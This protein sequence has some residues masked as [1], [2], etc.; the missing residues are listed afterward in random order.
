[1]NK[2][3]DLTSDDRFPKN[4]AMK[5][6]E[7]LIPM[8]ETGWAKY[9]TRSP[10]ARSMKFF[11]PF[12]SSVSTTYANFDVRL[13][14]EFLYSSKNLRYLETLLKEKGYRCQRFEVL[15]DVEGTTLITGNV[16]EITFR[17]RP[18]SFKKFWT[19]RR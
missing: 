11:F 14:S 4:V 17:R 8:I 1:M 5:N 9:L 15:G 2:F 6:V 19:R 13:Y 18:S 3:R 12:N 7:Q 16:C 10:N